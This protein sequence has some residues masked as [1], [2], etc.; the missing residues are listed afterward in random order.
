MIIET[1]RL[2][3]REYTMDDFNDLYELLSD[4]ITMSHYPKQYD[5]E[6]TLRWI[7]WCM[8]SSTISRYNKYAYNCSIFNKGYVLIEC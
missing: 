3:L 6:G 2:I 8:D 5:E 1:N 4:P 7:K